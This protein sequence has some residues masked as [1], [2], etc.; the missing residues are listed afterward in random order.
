MSTAV[1]QEDPKHR[2]IELS[3]GVAQPHETISDDEEEE[4]EEVYDEQ[5]SPVNVNEFSFENSNAKFGVIQVPENNLDISEDLHR[6]IKNKRESRGE[7]E[8]LKLFF[9]LC[10][11]VSLKS[12]LRTVFFLKLWDGL[13][14]LAVENSLVRELLAVFTASFLILFIMSLLGKSSRDALF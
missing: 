6:S 8:S 13:M 14:I 9:Y 7:E 2:K 3:G 4:K 10:F 5:D 12:Y 1:D 11:D